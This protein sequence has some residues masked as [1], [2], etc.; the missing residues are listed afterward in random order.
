MENMIFQLTH[1]YTLL[2]DFFGIE[3]NLAQNELEKLLFYVESIHMQHMPNLPYVL[4]D[5]LSEKDVIELLPVLYKDKGFKF[6]PVYQKPEQEFITIDLWEIENS[7]RRF[8][9][10]LS[11]INEKYAI[12]NATLSLMK[13]YQKEVNAKLKKEYV[14]NNDEYQTID[15]NTKNYN[16]EAEILQKIVEGEVIK[17]EWNIT[18]FLEKNLTGMKFIPTGEKEILV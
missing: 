1:N 11:E 12:P 7:Y 14:I 17:P 2:T 18:S 9:P 10:I 15:E 16:Q 3:T 13:F 6:K 5:S 8:K 4:D